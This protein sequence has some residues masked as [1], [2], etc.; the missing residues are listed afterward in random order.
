[1]AQQDDEAGINPPKWTASYFVLR[2]PHLPADAVERHGLRALAERPEVR[3][4]VYVASP[5]LARA[6]TLWLEQPDHPAAR[7]VPVSLYRYLWRMS[8]RPTPFGLFAGNALGQMGGNTTLELDERVWRHTRLDMAWLFELVRGLEPVLRSQLVYRV[9]TSLYRAADQLRY[10]EGRLNAASGARVNDQIS[11]ER[12]PAIEAVLAAAPATVA[13]LAA[14]VQTLH[15]DLPAEDCAA[16]VEG[17]IDASVL[18]SQLEPAVIGEDPLAALVAQVRPLDAALGE[19]LSELHAALRALDQRGLGQSAQVYA[20]I[21]GLCARL[22][23]PPDPRHLLH[24][25]LYRGG[26]LSLGTSVIQAIHE[27]RDLLLR[28]LPPAPDGLAALRDNFETRWGGAEQALPDVLDDERGVGFAGSGVGADPSPLLAGLTFPGEQPAEPESFGGRDRWMLRRIMAAPPGG[29]WQLDEDDL[30]ELGAEVGQPMPDSYAFMGVLLAESAEAIDR[31]DFDL[32]VDSFA[33]PSGTRLMGR[34]CLGDPALRARVEADHRAEESLAPDAVFAEI[35]HSPE[36]RMANVLARPRLRAT[37]IPY[38]S[39]S[40]APA[41][42]QIRVDDLRLSTN[43]PGGSFVLRSARLDREV[44]P[45]L[46]SAHNHSMGDLPIY[47]FL[48]AVQTQGVRAGL[49]WSWGALAAAPWLP[50]VRRGRIILC[51]ARWNLSEADLRPL[52]AA[53][54]AARLAAA[55]ELRQRLG[56]PRHVAVLQSDN[57]LPIDLENPLALDALA[58]EAQ[59]SRTLALQESSSSALCVRGPGG[60]Y[61]HEIVVPFV[62][63]GG[64]AR[65]PLPRTTGGTVRAWPPG[66][67]WLTAKIYTGALTADTLMV[68]ALQP[69]VASLRREGALAGWFFIR[70]G[71][72]D[73]HVRLRLKADPQLTPGLVSALHQALEPWLLD[74][75]VWRWV[76]DT[77]QPEV[78]RYGGPVGIELAERLFEADS[79]AV[80]SILALLTGDEG[81][82]ARWR[83]ALRSAH[84]LLEDLGIPLAERPSLLMAWRDATAR[85]FRTDRAFEGRLSQRFRAERPSLVSL[86]EPTWEPDHPLAPGLELLAAR[87]QASAPAVAALCKASEEG[88]L[89]RTVPDLAGSYVHMA[90]NRM[91]RS[92]TNAQE[93]VLYDFLARLYRS[94]LARGRQG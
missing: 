53:Q 56:L 7:N 14:A 79:D 44:I 74:G 30:R 26:D 48:G 73:W 68:Q 55:G 63:S 83:L 71:D 66:S 20:D 81:S 12:T 34:F 29:E 33:G 43:G 50:R 21:A 35:A 27:A 17:L 22:P 88:H 61:T 91:L 69:L 62:R 36:G 24:V 64:P 46:C 72:P 28:L 41:E 52:L 75:R 82:D 57:A 1:M 2:T 85:R 38:Q 84:A 70:Y 23:A 25:D 8:R 90:V 13:E 16:F 94:Q 32:L 92:E 49:A 78:E 3:E 5:D 45:R 54:G 87:T 80:A 11:L 89:Q 37:E 10:A 76:L 18:H 4:A 6:L 59:R 9:N 19:D 60:S 51:L 42:N 77:Y 93:L 86:L 67:A 39:P 31:G 65:P 15:P 58:V 47:R 40:S